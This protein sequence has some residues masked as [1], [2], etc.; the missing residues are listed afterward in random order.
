MIFFLIHDRRDRFSDSLRALEDVAIFNNVEDA[1]ADGRQPRLIVI[2]GMDGDG[3]SLAARA[4][5]IFPEVPIIG[6]TG[7]QST[8]RD[9][10]QRGAVLSLIK[11]VESPSE[12]IKR[13]Q[14]IMYG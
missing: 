2:D 5:S 4:V 14:K 9:F 12:M 7:S 3:P 1:N 13:V 6:Y 10:V 8:G 11:G